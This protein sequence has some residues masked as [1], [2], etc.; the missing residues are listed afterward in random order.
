VHLNTILNILP[1]L[2]IIHLVYWP[3]ISV[4]FKGIAA[5]KK[6]IDGQWPPLNL[7]P[8]LVQPSFPTQVYQAGICYITIHWEIFKKSKV[9]TTQC[10]ACLKR[11]WIIWRWWKT[12]HKIHKANFNY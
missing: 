3:W 4:Y 11:Y 7:R 9:F 10:L 6:A 2:Q 5:N 12:R 1:I 8:E